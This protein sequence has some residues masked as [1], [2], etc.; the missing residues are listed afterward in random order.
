MDSLCSTQNADLLVEG[1]SAFP[2]VQLTM[3]SQLHDVLLSE[4]T[5]AGMDDP[6]AE[7]RALFES[8]LGCSSLL[9]PDKQVGFYP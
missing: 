6:P 5:V 4:I 1:R 8:F 2:E 3:V 7:V 9:T